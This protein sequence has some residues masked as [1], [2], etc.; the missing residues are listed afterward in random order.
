[1]KQMK[2]CGRAISVLLVMFGVNFANYAS[3]E[4]AVSDLRTKGAV[5]G[6]AEEPP[7]ATFSADGKLSGAAADLT[8]A[9]LKKMGIEK[10]TPKVTDWGSLIPGV[11]AHRFDLVST[12]L[13]IKPAR[14]KAVLFSQP[15]V[16]TSEGFAVK[17]GNPLNLTTF[18]DLKKQ[19]VR[20]GVCGGCAEEKRALEVGVARDQL[21]TL[22]DA[23]NGME[24]LK[25]GRID[26]VIWPDATLASTISKMKAQDLE[27]VSPL[28]GEPLQCSGVVFNAG[29]RSFRDEYDKMLAE[30]KRNGEF[31]TIISPYGFNPAFA[32]SVTRDVLC[33]GPN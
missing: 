27:V 32:K 31:D 26:V 19:G 25:A 14:C 6:L 18:Q 1:M 33:E 17:K 5:L 28:K 15:D 29:D 21:V 30:M 4:T 16:C 24:M 8:V 2:F 7:Y 3:A 13:Y 23:F 22:S 9:V 12:G 10:V 20:V 11:Q